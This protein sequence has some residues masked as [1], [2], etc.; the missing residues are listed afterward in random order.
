MFTLQTSFKP[1]LLGGGGGKDQNLLV[2]VT[3]NSKEE[4]SEDFCPN[5]A[6]EFG[7]WIR[8]RG[9]LQQHGA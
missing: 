1:F 8:T 3:V 2:K 4:K 6:Q 9:H 7:L 5:Y